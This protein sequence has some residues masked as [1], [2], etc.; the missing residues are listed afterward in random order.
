MQGEDGKTNEAE[1]QRKF[2]TRE[3]GPVGQ[4]S[5]QDD[6]AEAL[7]RRCRADRQLHLAFA[8]LFVGAV[9]FGVPGAQLVDDP[10]RHDSARQACREGGS[11]A[12]RP[13]R[14]DR[15]RDVHRRRRDGQED[16]R[17]GRRSAAT[18]PTCASARAVDRHRHSV[19]RQEGDKTIGQSASMRV[20]TSS[21]PDPRGLQR[22]GEDSRDG[23]VG[24][25]HGPRRHWSRTR[26][27]T[28][29]A[30]R[31]SSAWSEAAS[32]VQDLGWGPYLRLVAMISIALGVFNLLPIP[33]LDGGRAVFIV[34][35]MCAA[36]RSTPRAKRSST[37][38]AS[39]C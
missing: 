14:R 32:E 11:A 39:P 30:C 5:S 29:R 6:L 9:A 35:E 7:D 28:P 2:R 3:P 12:R 31:A 23:L 33:A 27:S 22:A 38:P 36:A 1:Q 25:F 16:S 15:R 8:I 34:A 10:N 24:Q 17:V 37:S 21:A 13:G 4:F 18:S 26:S 20:P 19:G